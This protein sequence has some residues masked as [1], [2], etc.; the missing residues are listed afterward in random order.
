MLDPKEIQKLFDASRPE[1]EAH[2]RE[3]AKREAA[4]AS[5]R[6][7]DR[8]HHRQAVKRSYAVTPRPAPAVAKPAPTPVRSGPFRDSA[9]V[10]RLHGKTRIQP[11]SMRD[12]V[13][14]QLVDKEESATPKSV[15]ELHKALG[16]DP[17]PVLGKLREA[18][19]VAIE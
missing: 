7:K 6:E 12:K 3:K 14:R 18:G 13:L 19:W 10:T 16:F 15:S 5:R 17:R 4:E 1:F 8:R 2:A 9:L 11:G